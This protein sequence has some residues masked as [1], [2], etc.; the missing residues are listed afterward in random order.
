VDYKGM[1]MDALTNLFGPLKWF[2]LAI[3]VFPTCCKP[4]RKSEAYKKQKR[5]DN[6]AK[7]YLEEMDI[8]GQLR[9]NRLTKMVFRSTLKPEERLLV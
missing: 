9:T 1:F 4:D 2:C 3:L 5:Y 7:R 6:G 8:V